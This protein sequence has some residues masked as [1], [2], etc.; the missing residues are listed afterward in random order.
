MPPESVPNIVRSQ[1][2]NAGDRIPEGGLASLPR[3]LTN[4][5]VLNSLSS[6]GETEG[7]RFCGFG[8]LPKMSLLR[9]VLE[10]DR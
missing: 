10:V 3:P 2:M 9:R 4:P 6:I 7:E 5:C 8:V 1:A